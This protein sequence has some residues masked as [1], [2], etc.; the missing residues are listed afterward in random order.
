ME[1]KINYS[2]DAF[3]YGVLL[4]GINKKVIDIHPLQGS[5][6]TLKGDVD[7]GKKWRERRS[8]GRLLLWQRV[9]CCAPQLW[10]P[11]WDLACHHP[12]KEWVGAH[13][14]MALPE[15]LYIINNWWYRESLWFELLSILLLLCYE[16]GEGTHVP[17]CTYEDQRT[18][19]VKLLLPPLCGIQGLNAW[20]QAC[21]V[22]VSFTHWG[23][24][25]AL[26]HSHW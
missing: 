19:L 5:G 6:N 18:T 14:A 3:G 10:S 7:K 8:M 17:L 25:L 2:I 20:H 1:A 12:V 13:R 26:G 23:I 11:G 22:S 9:S 21:T 24:W 4:Q 16:I 15:G